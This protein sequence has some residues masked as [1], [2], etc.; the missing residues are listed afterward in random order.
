[1]TDTSLAGVV[2]SITHVEE[3]E[4]HHAGVGTIVCFG[5]TDNGNSPILTTIDERVSIWSCPCAVH[6]NASEIIHLYLNGT[7]QGQTTAGNVYETVISR[8]DGYSRRGNCMQ[9]KDINLMFTLLVYFTIV[10][11][12]SIFFIEHG[13]NPIEHRKL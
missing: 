7:S 13:K 12:H 5:C 9:N 8:G 4:H 1:M 11:W 6:Y 2:P 3:S 10:T